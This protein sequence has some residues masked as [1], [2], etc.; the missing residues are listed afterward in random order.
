MH[1]KQITGAT[2]NIFLLECNGLSQLDALCLMILSHSCPASGPP[3]TIKSF[4]FICQPKPSLIQ[5][6]AFH[7]KSSLSTYISSISR[8]WVLYRSAGEMCRWTRSYEREQKRDAI[9]GSQRQTKTANINQESCPI[10]SL[11]LAIAQRSLRY[12]VDYLDADPRL[13]IIPRTESTE[14]REHTCSP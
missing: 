7:F 8:K 12:C 11:P 6:G 2:I 4:C 14:L 5:V 3:N 9:S 10:R 1:H 13:T